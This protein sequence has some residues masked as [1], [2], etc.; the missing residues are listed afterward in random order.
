MPGASET[1]MRN[2]LYPIE[3]LADFS[4]EVSRI[5]DEHLSARDNAPSSA[6]DKVEDDFNALCKEYP[7]LA[8]AYLK[9]K[10]RDYEERA[11][12]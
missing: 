10:A 1:P 6:G 11:T 3:T 2:N 5:I 9:A 4:K 7:V 12:S 8:D